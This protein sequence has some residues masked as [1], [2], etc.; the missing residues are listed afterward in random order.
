M[1]NL[2]KLSSLIDL[3]PLSSAEA[4]KGGCS[5]NNSYTKSSRN[6]GAGYSR[7]SKRSSCGSSYSSQTSH[8]K[9]GTTTPEVS[10]RV[11]EV[12]S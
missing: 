7:R 1:K 9:C 8:Y 10:Y 2:Q 12:N 6:C 3:T 11:D 4:I 5:S